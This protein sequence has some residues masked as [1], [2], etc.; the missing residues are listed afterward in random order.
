MTSNPEKSEI[1]LEHQDDIRNSPATP[2]APTTIIL[3]KK[4]VVAKEAIGGDYEELPKG[5]YWSKDFL[6][7]L[8]VCFSF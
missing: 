7:T 8:T 2:H 1:D 6:G 5:Y 4:D 3:H